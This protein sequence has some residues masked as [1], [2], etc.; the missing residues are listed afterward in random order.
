MIFVGVNDSFESLYQAIRRCWR[1]GQTKEVHV[2]II[3]SEM[4]ANVT[5]N[6]QRKEANMKL[7]GKAMLE[8]MHSLTLSNLQSAPLTRQIQ[9]HD[10]ELELPSWL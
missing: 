2:Y 4:E 1:F 6:L 10:Q 3:A 5:R 7:M 8:H 9:K